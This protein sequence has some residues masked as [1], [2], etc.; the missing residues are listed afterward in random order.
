MADVCPVE[1]R[2]GDPMRRLDDGLGLAVQAELAVLAVAGP[3]LLAR[4]GEDAVRAVAYEDRVDARRDENS[5]PEAGEG[6]TPRLSSCGI[7]GTP[8]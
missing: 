1:G 8:T 6:R 4:N 5:D 3:E 2:E 7:I